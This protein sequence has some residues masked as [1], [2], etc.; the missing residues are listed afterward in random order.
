MLSPDR[1]KPY[2]LHEDR[3]LRS[4]ARDYF[5]DSWSRDPDIIPLIL[6]AHDR[7]GDVD[8]GGFYVSDHLL[9]SESALDAVLTHLARSE[10]RDTIKVL[11]GV[12]VRVPGEWV[13]AREMAFRQHPN[14]WPTVI[15]RLERRRDLVGMSAEK[16]WDELHV[17]AARISNEPGTEEADF[18]LAQDL[19]DALSSRDF[20]DVDTVCGLLRS[21]EPEEGWLEIFLVELAGAR[22]IREAVPA[23]VDKLHLDADYVL[24]SSTDSLTRIGSTEAV[25]LI[26]AAYPTADESFKIYAS[27]V[28]GNIKQPESEE[29]VLALLETEVD[30]F[31]RMLLC[32]QLCKLVSERGIEVVRE[33]IA[34]GYDRAYCRLEDE[35]LAV[36]DVLGVE[37]PEADRWRREREQ[38]RLRLEERIAEMERVENEL[39]VRR[40]ERQSSYSSLDFDDDLDAD[41]IEIDGPVTI[42]RTEPRVGRNDPCPCGSG[43]K[44]KKCCGKSA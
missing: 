32:N 28:L 10:D 13:T 22:Q 3:Y 15:T 11:N 20:P 14:V 18:D 31:Y 6:E 34:A 9:M 5:I 24:E 21:L 33:Q 7:F 19:I 27:D 4:A 8:L 2:L 17:V 41:P 36:V 43:K 38:E 12:L 23:I 26:H 1:I 30:S 42:R 44:F 37:I 25:R 29:A 40:A 35:L 39:K 16:L